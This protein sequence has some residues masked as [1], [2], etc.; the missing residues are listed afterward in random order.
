LFTL[1]GKVER[2]RPSR[3]RLERLLSEGAA[4][5]A[6]RARERI[7][8]RRRGQARASGAARCIVIEVEPRLLK[9]GEEYVVRYFLQNESNGPLLIAGASIQNHIGESGVTGGK[10]EPPPPP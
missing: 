3:K 5:R 10:V 6:R 7:A 1:A 2:R 8:A 4:A 9:P